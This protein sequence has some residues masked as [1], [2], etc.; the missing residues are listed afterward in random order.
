MP[1]GRT[2]LA[3]LTRGSRCSNSGDQLV[4]QDRHVDHLHFLVRELRV[5]SR[6]LANPGDQPLQP[7]DVACEHLE[8][9]LPFGVVVGRG[10]DLRG[11][12]NR[13]QRVLEL[14]RDVARKRLEQ[15][16]V[17]IEPCRELFERPR[18]VSDL[19]LAIDVS[20]AGRRRAAV[21]Q[22]QRRVTQTDERPNER[23]RH[24]QSDDDGGGN[25]RDDDLEDAQ[26][27]LVERLQDAERR[28]RHERG[29][30]N[31]SRRDG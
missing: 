29:A 13:G 24:Q 7:V 21:R 14:V 18:Q 19:V 31:A 30:D 25:R 4:K 11:N 2:R 16:D 28:L 6:Q 20:E 15:L 26:P 8:K 23:R 12:A 10:D 27:D 22:R 1:N 3:S 9:T 17:R 5:D